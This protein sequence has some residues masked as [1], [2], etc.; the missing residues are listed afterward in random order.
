MF[1]HFIKPEYLANRARPSPYHKTKCAVSGEKF[2]SI[3]IKMADLRPLLT[4]RNIWKN[5]PDS[6]TIR[7]ITKQNVQ[8]SIEICPENV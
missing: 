1:I 4:L 2:N 8:L 7:P 5:A 3:K 6:K